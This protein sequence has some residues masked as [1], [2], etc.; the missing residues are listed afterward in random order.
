MKA[1]L[2]FL[3]LRDGGPGVGTARPL[4]LRPRFGWRAR[5]GMAP[6]EAAF[7][8]VFWLLV[9]VVWVMVPF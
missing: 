7:W 2:M 8:I 9:A 3:D 6:F 1:D 5:S 4:R